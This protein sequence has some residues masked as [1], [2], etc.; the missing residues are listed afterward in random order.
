[1]K[2]ITVIVF[3]QNSVL[4]PDYGKP[5]TIAFETS[6]HNTKQY[7]NTHYGNYISQYYP[8]GHFWTQKTKYTDASIGKND[9]YRDVNSSLSYT[10]PSPGYLYVSYQDEAWAFKDIMSSL[11][12]NN[13]YS[14]RVVIYRDGNY[15]PAF[16]ETEA[17]TSNSNASLLIPVAK[18]DVIYYGTW[19]DY[20]AIPST[21]QITFYPGKSVDA[22]TGD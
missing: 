19:Y 16:N 2:L 14:L 11:A 21:Y 9:S 5:I 17:I 7:L 6:D 13:G 4:V 15:I 8:S 20:Q 1:M 12:H 3:S 18:D 22:K 10:I